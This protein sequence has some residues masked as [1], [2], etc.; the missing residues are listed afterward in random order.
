[1]ADKKVCNSCHYWITGGGG[2]T[3]GGG[4]F[5]HHLLHTGKRRVEIDGV[6]MSLVPRK[7]KRGGKR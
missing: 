7:R 1:M 6:C 5:C 3:G 4:K 2:Y